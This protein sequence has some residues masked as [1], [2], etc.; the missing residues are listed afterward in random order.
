MHAA[1]SKDYN[2]YVSFK[3]R[4]L[5][6]Y[7]AESVEYFKSLES[8]EDWVVKITVEEL[9]SVFN[10]LPIVCQKP[11]DEHDA[12]LIEHLI[13]LLAYLPLVDSITAL[14][15][16]GL[17][18]DDYGFTIYEIAYHAALAESP[19]VRSSTIVDRVAVVNRIALFQTIKGKKI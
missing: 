12:N 5:A 11:F 10:K 8:K 1:N 3:E 6:Q 17:E 16:L 7:S 13:K 18:N 14:S 4:H 9:I 2:D 15:F 19:C